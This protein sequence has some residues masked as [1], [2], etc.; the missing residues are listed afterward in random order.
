MFLL[1]KVRSM[2]LSN[3][4]R[5]FAIRAFEE[6]IKNDKINVTKII[7]SLLVGMILSSYGYDTKLAAAGYLINVL[8]TDFTI[9]DLAKLFGGDVASLLVTA[10]NYSSDVNWVESKRQMLKAIDGLPEKNMILICAD[11]VVELE[12]LKIYL[13]KSKNPKALKT[14]MEDL[15][16]YF[17]SLSECISKSY[18]GPLLD[19]LNA[20]IVDA[21]E[22]S[23]SMQD[24]E[25]YESEADLYAELV[26]LKRVVSMRNPYIVKFTSADKESSS[27]LSLIY[28]F[29]NDVDFK[30]R[31][32]EEH[33]PSSK[34][35]VDL[36]NDKASISSLEKN[37]LISS[38]LKGD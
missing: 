35:E 28:D 36:L 18:N 29:M 26:K 30:I 17:T 7:H 23:E 19:R 9:D 5:S 27:I 14:S 11:K 1:E 16:W 32:V 3:K 20:A 24:V 8:D 4:A 15:K 13:K 37:L 38:S 2:T 22:N 34:Y 12:N 10:Q 31:V 21:F 25:A 33:V 6:K